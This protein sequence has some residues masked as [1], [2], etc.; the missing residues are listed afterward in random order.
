MD[1]GLL[2]V[3]GFAGD[4]V[5]YPDTGKRHCG[6]HTAVLVGVIEPSPGS[7]SYG[8]QPRQAEYFFCYEFG[9]NWRFSCMRSMLYAIRQWS[10]SPNLI[11]KD[12]S[13]DKVTP[14]DLRPRHAAT[15]E[16]VRQIGESG[17]ARGYDITGKISSSS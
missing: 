16:N 1:E 3:A 14:S 9:T 13:Q 7:F 2:S 17:V 10:P 12:G 4:S 5:S 15:F 6:F 8:L 11:D